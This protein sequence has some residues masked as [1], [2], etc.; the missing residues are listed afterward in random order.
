MMKK[1]KNPG[2]KIKMMEGRDY[3][4]KNKFVDVDSRK[5]GKIIHC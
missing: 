2:I 4:R 3:D 5:N 1:I